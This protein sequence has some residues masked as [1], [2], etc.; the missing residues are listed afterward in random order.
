MGWIFQN[1]ALLGSRQLQPLKT[2][3][4][5]KKI[6]AWVDSFLLSLLKGVYFSGSN[7]QLFVFRG[8]FE[9]KTTQ[10]TA[11][12]PPPVANEVVNLTFPECDLDAEELGGGRHSICGAVDF[13]WGNG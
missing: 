5:P 11:A 2:N 1:V 3:M 4:E 10:P 9:K 7:N 13:F 6:D 8:Y 12:K